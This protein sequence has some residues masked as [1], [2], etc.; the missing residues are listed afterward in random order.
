MNLREAAKKYIRFLAGL[1]FVGRFVRILGAAW[2]GPQT[3]VELAEMRGALNE[4]SRRIEGLNAR[5]HLREVV[6]GYGAAIRGMEMSL[7]RHEIAFGTIR[8]SLNGEILGHVRADIQPLQEKLVEFAHR[9]DELVS[10]NSKANERL[11]WLSADNDNLR[12][13]LEFIRK[14]M[15]FELRRQLRSTGETKSTF[16]GPRFLNKE[17]I[18]ALHPLKLNL[19]C[20]HITKPDHVNVDYRELPGVDLVSDVAALPFDASSVSAI[21][22]A[23]LV[24]HFTL[25]SLKDSV[26]PHWISLLEAGGSLTLIAPNSQAMIEGYMGGEFTF[27]ELREV[28]FGGQEYEGD[29]HFTML[30]PEAAS[31]L[32]REVGF[33]H[34]EIMASSRR[35]G[36]CYEF[37]LYAKK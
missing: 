32:L 28:T 30:T 31:N 19:G 5:E 6:D 11:K 17:R 27:K 26:L 10:E 34:V 23:H 8:G 36:D 35:N 21:Y 4:I 9:S 7:R 29:F 3:R 13:R 12:S 33:Q 37:E 22:A 18:A 2:R 14:E 24:E 20:G 1:P 16:D 25:Q 15:M